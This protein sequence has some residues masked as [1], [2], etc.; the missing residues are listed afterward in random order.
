MSIKMM[1]KFSIIFLFVLSICSFDLNAKPVTLK[2]I[3]WGSQ[4]RHDRTLKVIELFKK[5]NPDIKIEPMYISWNGYFEKLSTLVAANEMPDIV[6]MTIQ[7]MP[8]YEEK[9][10]FEDLKTVRTIDLS[11]IEPAGLE[12]GIFGG[13]LLGI[14]LGATAP[15]LV[16]NREIFEKAG[17][18]F[19]DE[20]WTW[21][22]LE[23]ASS[24]IY[25]KLGING[26]F[27]MALDYN[28]FEIYAR[29]KGESIYSFDS[30][31]AGFKES[32]LTEFLEMCL[33]MQ[34][35]GAMENIRISG[36]FRSNEELSS[37]A[38][39]KTAMR[40]M[41]SNKIIS[42]FN[43]LK[44]V[45]G[46]T[47]YPGPDNSKGMYSKPS[48]YFSISK[49]SRYKEEAGK[50]ISFFINNISAN[51]I[52]NSER[53]ISVFSRVRNS[54][55]NNLDPQNAEV[56]NFIGYVNKYSRHPLD[57]QFPEYDREVKKIMQS[58]FEEVLLEKISPRE[59]SKKL[60]SQWNY[61]LG[62]SKKP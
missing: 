61:I 29:E 62:T 21:K 59:G 39:G 31:K 9:N 27:N 7:N 16:Y 17:L 30:K 24:S 43:S 58:I 44:K 34:K 38:K 53:G 6:Q 5:E 47:V 19:P 8:Q 15:S 48:M 18:T 25:S 56:F 22:D 12:S 14:T 41:W 20:N 35:S 51:K 4:D 2:I 32:T 33:R 23:K 11:D 55:L 46:I 40:F 52:L 49:K 26:I 57:P 60:I 36:E 1:K 37:Y 42:V 45:S 10:L 54:F 3:W 50:F 28:D 13:K